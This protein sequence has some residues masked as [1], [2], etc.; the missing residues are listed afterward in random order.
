MVW[1]LSWKVEI[2]GGFSQKINEFRELS[3]TYCLLQA[4]FK[5]TW[6]QIYCLNFSLYWLNYFSL[7]YF[8]KYPINQIRPWPFQ[9]RQN[10]TF[11][12]TLLDI[13]ADINKTVSTDLISRSEQCL[14][15]YYLAPTPNPTKGEEL[16][17]NILRTRSFTM[18]LYLYCII[19]T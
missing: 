16:Y 18:K 7:I 6:I 4:Y 2:S 13:E 8:Q 9:A 10:Q 19:L 17:N 11:R 14:L 5:V 3:Q 1:L 15:Y 12:P